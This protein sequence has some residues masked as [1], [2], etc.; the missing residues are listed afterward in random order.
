M[1]RI[2]K[3]L[4]NYRRRYHWLRLKDKP[5]NGPLYINVE[6]TNACNLRCTMCS[7][8]GS[9]KSGFMNLDLFR[10]IIDQ[11]PQAGV[12]EVSLFLAGES[13]LH[14]DLPYMVEYTV[15]HGLESWL[16]TNGTLLTKEKSQQLLDAGLDNIWISLDG[17]TK[18]DYES[19]RPGADFDEV[20][21]NL[22]DLLTLKREKGDGKPDVRI[23][24]LK[25]RDNPHQEVRQ[26]FLDI[27]KGLPLDKVVSRNPHDWR[28]EKQGIDIG[29]GGNL[30][31][32]C[33]ALWS[34]MSIAWDGRVLG[35]SA[36]LNGNH[37]FG[38]L[39]HQSIMEVW[40]CEDMVRHRR[41]LREGRY[42][43]LP[44]C[45]ECHSLWY[46]GNPRLHVLSLLPPFEQIKPWVRRVYDPGKARAHRA[47][48]GA[49]SGSG[50][51]DGAVPATRDSD[52]EGR[53]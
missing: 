27:F 4:A 36:D 29:D 44:L 32:P 6:A 41:L 35:C 22:V 39:N 48:A 23:H 46:E 34:A 20:V 40:N 21:Q 5:P 8:D 25:T 38:D 15:D 31:Y 26:E 3:R 17:D 42:R 18:E 33:E 43:E 51:R 53:R 49:R 16:V 45:A 1:K 14:K 28:G 19:L 11:A 47:A 12:Y 50:G 10:R 37:V 24:M 13:L 30:Y 52:T 9:R 7:R 2:P